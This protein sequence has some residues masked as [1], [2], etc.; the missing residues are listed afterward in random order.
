[1]CSFLWLSSIPL[2]IY[3]YHNFF[4]LVSANGHLGGFHVLSIV[5]SA[6]VNIGVYVTF[7]IMIL[8]VYVLS[9]GIVGS[10]DSFISNFLRILYSVLHSD[11]I[12]LHCHKQHKRFPFSP[13]AFQ[14]FCRFF[15]DDHSDWCEVISHCSF[16][17]I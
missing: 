4:I 11:C 16:A 6:A 2:H 12:N 15:D 10:C 9:S 14:I 1:M 5:N 7:S 3:I 17:F 8:S 13:H